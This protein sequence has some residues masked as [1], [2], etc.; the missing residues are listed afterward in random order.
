[1]KTAADVDA[2]GGGNLGFLPVAL[3]LEGAIDSSAA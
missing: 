2:Q 1:L 3:L